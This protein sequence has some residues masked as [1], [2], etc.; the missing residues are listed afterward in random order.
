M[1]RKTGTERPAAEAAG[2]KQRRER[3][4]KL[5][6]EASGVV[7]QAADVLEREVTAAAEGA[8]RA[9]KRLRAEGR[10]DTEDLAPVLERFRTDGHAILDVAGDRLDDLRSDE[11]QDL[12]QRFAA[13]AHTIFDTVVDLV[14]LTPR[15]VD[16]LG[17]L[18]TGEGGEGGGRTG[19]PI[20]GQPGGGK[21]GGGGRR[22]GGAA[23]APAGRGGSGKGGR[24][25]RS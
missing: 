6:G 16:R 11:T 4:R 17:G 21:P 25:G 5:G 14:E 12:L 22:P 9:E 19:Q 10:V 3:L 7:R 8:Q 23:G 24:P 15:L 1:A 2:E 13:D 18:G 20:A